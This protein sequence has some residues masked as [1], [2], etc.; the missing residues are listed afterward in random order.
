MLKLVSTVALSVV[1]SVASVLGL[2]KV[3]QDAVAQHEMLVEQTWQNMRASTRPVFHEGEKVCSGVMIEDNVMLTAA[4]CDTGTQKVLKKDQSIDLM[5]IWVDEKCPC[6]PIATALPKIDD[7]IVV[8]GFPLGG[9]KILT[10][11]RVQAFSFPLDSDMVH[12]APII[13]GNSGGPVFNKYGEVVGINSR[14]A[15]VNFQAV[16][17]L[18]VAIDLNKIRNFLER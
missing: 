15:S 6:A 12:T 8:V 17:H 3:H 4:H 10:E 7:S 16:T 18:A 11:G 9:A 14:V 1:L 2:V 13:F 5:L